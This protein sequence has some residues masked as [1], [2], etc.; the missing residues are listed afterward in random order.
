MVNC[1]L[2]RYGPHFRASFDETVLEMD[3]LQQ[4]LHDMAY[5]VSFFINESEKPIE[6][7]EMV[8]LSDEKYTQIATFNQGGQNARMAKIESCIK[9][10]LSEIQDAAVDLSPNSLS[11]VGGRFIVRTRQ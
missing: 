9:S 2:A 10:S 7:H 8:I 11:A 1:G 4:M 5:V 6:L 3:K